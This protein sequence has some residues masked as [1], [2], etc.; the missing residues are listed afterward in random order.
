MKLQEIFF[1]VHNVLQLLRSLSCSVKVV[2]V[3]GSTLPQLLQ[4][5]T[6]SSK[7]VKR[8]SKI[9]ISPRKSKY[10]THYV[11]LCSLEANINF[12]RSLF[13]EIT[14]LVTWLKSTLL[15]K[16]ECFD[17]HIFMKTQCLQTNKMQHSCERVGGGGS[18]N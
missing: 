6:L 15:L 9:I 17:T 10:A 5:M 3:L 7:V 12:Q 4:K 16:N 13:S 1:F 11:G 18:E 14:T 2:F 8:D